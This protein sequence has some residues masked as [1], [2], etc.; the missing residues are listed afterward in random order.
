[1]PRCGYRDSE[2]LKPDECALE[3]LP[4][5]SQMLQFLLSARPASPSAACRAHAMLDGSLLKLLK[6]HAT[7]VQVHPWA[8]EASGCLLPL[9]TVCCDVVA[10]P[11]EGALSWPRISARAM[12]FI[13]LVLESPAYLCKEQIVA[14][15][16]QVRALLAYGRLAASLNAVCAA[17][18]RQ[19]P[20]A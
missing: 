1:V 18:E 14:L 9:L 12:R 13:S 8:L 20:V 19:Q 2:T 7:V 6:L 11:S 5:T 10:Q 3:L 4:A 15:R 17:R 16:P